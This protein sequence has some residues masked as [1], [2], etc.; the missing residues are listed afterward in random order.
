M[1]QMKDKSKIS[2]DSLDEFEETLP[3][4]SRSGGRPISGILQEVVSHLTE[5]VRSE[6]R[7][8][9]A[10]IRQD[11]TDVAKASLFLVGSAVFASYGIGFVLLAGVYALATIM[12]SWASALIVGAGAGVPAAVLLLV[13]RQKMKLATMRPEKTIQSLQESVTWAKKETK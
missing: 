6:M 8:A 1:S 10:E 4:S 9:R 7:L 13:G 2:R 12:P 11:A 5:I 3:V